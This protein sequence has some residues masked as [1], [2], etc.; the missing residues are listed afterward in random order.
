M[1]E[2]LQRLRELA[3]REPFA[4]KM[5]I[6][7]LELKPGYALTE[8]PL[9]EEVLNIHGITHGGAIFSVVDVAFELASNSHGVPAFALNMDIAFHRPPCTPGVLRAEAREI[10]LGRTVA[11]YIIEARDGEGRLVAT[12]MATVHRQHP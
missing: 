1:S 3:E 9:A 10:S 8:M 5:G 11:T 2:E 4:R 7:V 12:C 6:R